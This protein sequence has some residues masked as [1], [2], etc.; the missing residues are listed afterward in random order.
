MAVKLLVA[1]IYRQVLMFA[2][3]A[4]DK[5]K[6]IDISKSK[7]IAEALQDHEEGEAVTLCLT[8]T[9]LKKKKDGTIQLE[10]SEAEFEEPE[11]DET[12]EQKSES[13]EDGP[14]GLDYVLAKQSG[15]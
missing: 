5:D 14:S 15:E 6:V 3:M 13:G 10:L 1:A 9:I 2:L 12:D 4:Q 8:G 7:L 11:T